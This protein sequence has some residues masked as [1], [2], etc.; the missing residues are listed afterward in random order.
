MVPFNMQVLGS[1]LDSFSASAGVASDFGCN[2]EKTYLVQFDTA[3]AAPPPDSVDV[4][5]NAVSD[6]VVTLNIDYE[7]GKVEQIERQ[8][9]DPFSDAELNSNRKVSDTGP[10]K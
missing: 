2:V 10:S 1:D 3:P 4:K 5:D 6:P 9:D 7:T 8:P